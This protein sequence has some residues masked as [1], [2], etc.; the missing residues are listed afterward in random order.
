MNWKWHITMATSILHRATGSALYAGTFLLVGWLVALTL[1]E[2]AYTSYSGL[3]GSVF[4]QIVL[5]GF[6]LAVMYHLANGIRHLVWDA[7]HG[8]KIGTAN[9]TAWATILF[10]IVSSVAIWALCILNIGG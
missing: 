10:A 1:G 2:E 3:I 9:A 7:G 8:Y 4:G 5:F 6:T